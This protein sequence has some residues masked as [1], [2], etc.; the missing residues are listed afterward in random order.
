MGV[1]DRQ[2]KD[3]LFNVAGII[4]NLFIL[5]KEHHKQYTKIRIKDNVYK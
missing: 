2:G 5:K 4:Y 3:G 1:A